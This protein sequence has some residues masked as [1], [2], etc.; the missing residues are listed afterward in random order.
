MNKF[1]KLSSLLI[2][3]LVAA[4]SS[5]DDNEA[6]PGHVLVSA[7]NIQGNDIIDGKTTTLR[8]NILPENAANKGIDWSISDKK[9]ADI[10]DAGVLNPKDNGEVTVTA[11]AQD[12][13][14]VSSSIL[15]KISGV[16]HG[17]IL[18]AENML[19][20]QRNNGGW[21]KEPH[22]DFSGYNREQTDAEISA[23]L[24]GK[25]KTDTTI[26]NDHTVGEIRA[27][28]DAYQVTFNPAYLEAAE[29]GLNYLF[30][31][32]YD[33]GGWPQYY[34]DKSGY[35]HQITF[36]DNAM[37][38]VMNFMWDISKGENDTGNF[39]DSYKEK[40]FNAFNKGIEVILK[41]QITVNGTKTAW[42]AQHDDITLLPAT[43]R[44]YELPSI[45]GSESVG[46]ARTL[47]LVES[48]SS[49]VKAA[50]KA[51]IEWFEDAKLYD[52]DTKKTADDVIVVDAPGNIIWARFY[53]LETN[54]PFFCGRDG[55]KKSTL[56]EIERE[57]RTGYAWYGTWP[58]N[59]IGS[60]YTNWKNKHGI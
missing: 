4:C 60:E 57:R 27:L 40:A 35:R 6:N 10:S 15:I 38:N 45:S 53:D 19:L 58:K 52:I 21:P 51:A 55:I 20:W 41:T 3:F 24:N 17:T 16:N 5:D 50:V 13:S 39:E 29:N 48:P 2:I 8:A 54:I 34:P 22:N 49:E 33:N 23:A 14:G 47:M 42:C 31:A 28:L 18:Q 36:N 26:D 11:T 7:I 25:S 30:E 1:L 59:I 43:A 32:Q 9:I 44:S 56:A 12:G 37:V 46:I